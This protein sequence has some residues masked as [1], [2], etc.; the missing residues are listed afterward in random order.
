LQE[1]RGLLVGNIAAVVDQ[2]R[3]EGEIARIERS[4]M[5]DR[6][7]GMVP[8]FVTLNPGYVVGLNRCS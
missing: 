5:Q 6:A 2:F 1:G 7:Y 4:E 3:L 8:D